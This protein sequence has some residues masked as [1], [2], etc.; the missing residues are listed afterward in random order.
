MRAHHALVHGLLSE[1]RGLRAIAR[2]LGW[3][4]HTVQRYSRRCSSPACPDLEQLTNSS[5]TSP[6]CSPSAP[7]LTC[8]TGSAPPA[9]HMVLGHQSRHDLHR[10]RHF[11]PQRL[12]TDKAYDI[13]ELRRWLRGKRIGVPIACRGIEPSER[14]GRRRWVIERTMNVLVHRLPPTQPPLRAPPPQLS[15]LSRSRR[16]PLLQTAS[17]S[18]HIG[19]GRK[20]K[21]DFFV[22]AYRA[23]TEIL[24]HRGSGP[25]SS[26]P[27]VLAVP[28]GSGLSCS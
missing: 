14:L 27:L 17:P 23:A 8:R 4:R 24:F 11:K 1:G 13:P 28:Q 3:G 7:V 19:H 25:V 2:H 6:K 12:Y 9:T 20:T 15:G 21:D 10:A 5:A 18:C 22:A 16:H 26:A